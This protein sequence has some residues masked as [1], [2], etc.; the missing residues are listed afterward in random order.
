MPAE[1]DDKA[2]EAVEALREATGGAD[3]RANLFDASTRRG[4][5]S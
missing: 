4:S 3:L 5:S 2:R 1:L